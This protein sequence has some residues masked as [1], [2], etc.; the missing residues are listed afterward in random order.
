MRCRIP[1]QLIQARKHRFHLD[2]NH[3]GQIC[4]DSNVLLQRGKEPCQRRSHRVQSRQ[5]FVAAEN[6]LCVRKKTQRRKRA[7]NFWN[8]LD[9]RAHLRRTARI[10][11]HSRHLAGDGR[12][13]LCA[14]C[15]R[16]N[17]CAPSA[18]DQGPQDSECS[19]FHDALPPRCSVCGG[20]Q[21]R[22]R[23]HFHRELGRPSDRLICDGIRRVD[24]QRVFAWRQCRQRQQ[25]LDRHLV[26]Y[27]LHV[28]GSF[29]ELHHLL[30]ALPH[31]VLERR[32]AL[33]RGVVR[34]QVV[35]LHVNSK[36]VRSRKISLKPWPHF[37]R[38]QHKL[39]R[40][41]LLRRH[42][43]DLIRQNQ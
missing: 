42:V 34:L 24:L 2:A 39:S 20:L 13:R 37:G 6:S 15:V 40:A 11:H 23:W 7:C 9:A 3:R 27:L 32:T 1:P 18:Q 28:C 17:P 8:Q 10:A 12:L 5:E 16:A 33:V 21:R 43:F 14:R 29:F 19:L 41:N 4:I 30:V 31:R 22:S 35:H 38:S 25:P 36:L 26:S